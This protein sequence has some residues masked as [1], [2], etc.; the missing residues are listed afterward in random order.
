MKL[1]KASGHGKNT[2]PMANKARKVNFPEEKPAQ[3]AAREEAAKER[4]QPDGVARRAKVA[5]V[6]QSKFPSAAQL[7]N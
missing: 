7:S 6:V 3:K 2:Y 4:S 1:S 5:G